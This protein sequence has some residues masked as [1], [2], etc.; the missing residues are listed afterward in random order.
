MIR[1]KMSS[2]LKLDPDETVVEW[3]FSVLFIIFVIFVVFV[4]S[5]PKP[6]G[7]LSPSEQANQEVIKNEN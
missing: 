2:M 1:T 5:P 3:L 4:V 6:P 7:Y